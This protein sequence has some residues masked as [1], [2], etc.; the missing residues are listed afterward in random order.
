MA[1]VAQKVGDATMSAMFR[2]RDGFQPL[3]GRQL[4][5]AS[6]KGWVKKGKDGTYILTPAG[7]KLLAANQ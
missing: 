3:T 7:K 2:L 4:T 1:K 5:Y 6:K